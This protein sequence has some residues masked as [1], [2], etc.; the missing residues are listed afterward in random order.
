MVTMASKKNDLS[1]FLFSLSLKLATCVQQPH[2]KALII[3]S[4]VEKFVVEGE[5]EMDIC[6]TCYVTLL[7]YL[8]SFFGN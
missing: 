6:T 5:V 7:K 2:C 3:F 1:N 8:P 4:F